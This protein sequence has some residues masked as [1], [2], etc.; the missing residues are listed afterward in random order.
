MLLIFV[1][2]IYRI[3]KNF[4][5][6]NCKLSHLIRTISLNYLVKN[7]SFDAA[8]RVYSRP[9]THTQ[10]INR[11]LSEATHLLQGKTIITSVN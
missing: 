8:C 9:H 2:S 4:T 7:K 10:H 11:L 3:L 1:Y 6:E 5:P